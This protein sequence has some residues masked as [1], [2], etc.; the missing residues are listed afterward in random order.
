[1]R[2]QPTLARGLPR[3]STRLGRTP[4]SFAD[5]TGS[6]NQ[7]GLARHGIFQK[8]CCA[9]RSWA[10]LPHVAARRI[11]YRL[12]Q[13]QG[14]PYKLLRQEPLSAFASALPPSDTIGTIP[15]GLFSL[16]FCS[17]VWL[18]MHSILP[19]GMAERKLQP[20]T[21]KPCSS[22][23]RPVGSWTT[24]GRLDSGSRK[25]S[26]AR[27]NRFGTLARW[28]A[29]R[30]V[31]GHKAGTAVASIAEELGQGLG[32]PVQVQVNG[33]SAATRYSVAR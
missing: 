26:K 21:R 20:I 32:V 30:I 19:K 33:S 6:D 10:K 17:P 28:R 1:M 15:A 7:C 12:L 2:R 29:E 14:S 18:P 31:G 25:R 8:A 22:G 9:V 27:L 24:V 23:H 5:A 3:E 4:H 13:A 11:C 16:S